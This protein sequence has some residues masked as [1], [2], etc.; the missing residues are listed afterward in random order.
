MLPNAGG[1]KIFIHLNELP[2]RRASAVGTL[3]TFEI[4]L[5]AN[6]R[7]CAVRAQW[8][9][10]PAVRRARQE[11]RETAQS[12]SGW[13]L[14]SLW[15]AAAWTLVFIGLTVY[16]RYPWKFV[17]A[18]FAVNLVTF[19]LYANDKTSAE[20]GRWRTPESNLHLVA[21]LGG[22]PAAALAQQAFRHKTSKESFRLIFW[23]SV[24]ANVCLM[25]WLTTQ[26][27]S[28]TIAMFS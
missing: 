26:H 21:L 23:C 22:W 27:A 16:G 28:M 17:A 25:L 10:S 3:I 18:W 6:R 19:V 12:R 7:S 15:L 5:D 14:F 1:R 4:G 2:G 20:R 11:R 9:A 8:V 13:G 24:I